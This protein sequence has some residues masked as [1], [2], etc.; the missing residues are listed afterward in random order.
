[1]E[2]LSIKGKTSWWQWLLMLALA[3]VLLYFAFRGVKWSDLVEGV[4]SCNFWWIGVSMIASIFGFIIRGLR[5]RLIMLP[6]NKSI[7]RREAYDGVTI[8]Y[9]S[10]F[11]LPRMGEFVR[12]GVISATKKASFQ[13]VLGT[14]V[15]ERSWDMVSYAVILLSII[16]IR[17]DKFGGF[18]QENIWA[19][20]VSSLPFNAIWLIIGILAI[21]ILLC[22]WIYK[23][24]EVLKQKKL[25]LKI[26][27]ILKGLWDGLVAG[28]KT[29]QRGRFFFYTALI[30]TCYWVMS[31]ATI[32]AFPNV[33]HLNGVDALFLMV[34]GGLGWIIPVQGGIGAYHFILALA[35]SSLYGIPQTSGVVFATI[36][37]E[38]QAFT[39]LLCGALS[40]ISISLSKRLSK[41][42]IN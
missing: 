19:P 3:L 24:R 41:K 22:L 8:M 9:L 18:M 42:K 10:N 2:K 4:K 35:L 17:W 1:M 30:W 25:F 39:M 27:N 6:L 28:F 12:C 14:V 29:E 31:I 40:L 13:S 34:I 33:A 21:V 36:S 38:S 37:H 7:T 5:W 23:K 32:K 15:L 26:Y 16:F 20:F 11:A